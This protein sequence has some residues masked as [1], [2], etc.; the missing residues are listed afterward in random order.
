MNDAPGILVL[1][2]D[3]QL[4]GR[5]DPDPNG[6]ILLGE[7]DPLPV[8]SFTIQDGDPFV[9]VTYDDFL[10]PADFV[11]YVGSVDAIASLATGLEAP[12]FNV[13]VPFL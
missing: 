10:P 7:G 6:L 1:T 3:E 5:T 4:E 9:T 12:A 2:F 11:T 8:N 13:P